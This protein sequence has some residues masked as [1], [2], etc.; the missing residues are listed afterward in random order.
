MRIAI[1]A[2]WIFH[3]I[4]GIGTYTQ[5]LI[6]N[7]AHRDRAND[8]FVFFAHRSL[9]ARTI[10]ATQL[11]AAP[12][13]T[14]KL[15]PYDLFSLRNQ[16]SLP[17]LLSDLKIDVYH[18]PNYMIPLRAFPLDRPGRIRCVTTIHDLIPLLFPDHAPKSK[19][20]RLMPV[21]NWIMRQVGRRSDVIVTVSQSSRKDIIRLLG[22]PEERAN[23]VR[24]IPNG[25]SQIYAPGKTQ[26]GDEKTILYVGR[27][28][29]YKNVTCLIKAFAEVLKGSLPNAKLRL[30]GPEDPRYPEPRLKAREL[31]V[32]EKIVWSG[33]VADDE[34]KH[35]YQNA[36][37]LVLASHYEGFGLPVVEA[38]KCGTP[39]ICSNRSSLPE[40]VGDAAILVDPDNHHEVADAITLLLTDTHLARELRKKGVEQA[41][42][43]TWMHASDLTVEAYQQA[44]DMGRDDLPEP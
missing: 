38:M 44:F 32:E 7:L 3:E 4:S 30:I 18:A 36:N 17:G 15:L 37:V 9:Q 33:Y 1:D 43:Y 40:I 34:L 6:R 14:T 42:Q 39:V 27:F 16:W 5:E 13:F 35:A 28:D 22:I 25:V 11:N 31:G 41:R 29:P 8:Y 23:A 24:V 20:A 19:K 21:F 2:R 12:N 26:V 10:S